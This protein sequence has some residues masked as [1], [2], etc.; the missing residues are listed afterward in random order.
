[1]WLGLWLPFSVVLLAV[2]SL[3]D[4]LHLQAGDKILTAP[5]T[6]TPECQVS[7]RQ[8]SL[9]MPK[10]LRTGKLPFPPQCWPESGR[11]LFPKPVTGK[12]ESLTG[13][14]RT[15]QNLLTPGTGSGSLSHGAGCCV[16]E[17][18]SRENWVPLGRR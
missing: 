6:T 8:V 16:E 10:F 3:T 1:M 5:R 4:W 15:N 17:S 13:L 14:T 2:L 12:E 11:F 9:P 7:S 18:G